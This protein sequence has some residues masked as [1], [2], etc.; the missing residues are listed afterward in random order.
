[1]A[2]DYNKN[3]VCIKGYAGFVYPVQDA[4][5]PSPNFPDKFIIAEGDSWFHIGGNVGVGNARN[6]LDKVAIPNKKAF[7]L[8]MALFGDSVRRIADSFES[9]A[10]REA[11]QQNDWQLIL[12]SGGGNDLIDALT[13]KSAYVVNGM[14]LSIVQASADRGDFMDYINQAHLDLLLDFL[15]E[16]YKALFRYIQGTR[17][18]DVPIV[19]HTYDYPTPRDAPAKLFGLNKGPW[20]KTAFDLKNVPTQ[21]Y[22]I[23]IADYIFERLAQTLLGL[24]NDNIHVVK[25][26][27]ILKRA[28]NVPSNSN[29]WLNEIHPNSKGLEKLAVKINAKIS[30]VV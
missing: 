3:D 12:L 19:I 29:D 20:L 26:Y 22:R 16:K 24:D 28:E 30:E 9:S 2:Y 15:A 6:L 21:A 23:K 7:L 8:N 4:L 10:F 1:M 25:T 11:L 14:A 13:E 18:A 27:G 5:Q 17:N